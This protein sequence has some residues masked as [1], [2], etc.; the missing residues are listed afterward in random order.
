MYR[1]SLLCKHFW[2]WEVQIK[3]IDDFVHLECNEES[4][5]SSLLDLGLSKWQRDPY[6]CSVSFL[7]ESSCVCFLFLYGYR[8]FW[9]RGYPNEHSIISFL[10]DR[11][12]LYKQSHVRYYG[13][14]HQLKNFR[15]NEG[16]SFK[17]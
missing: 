10:Q 9:I 13:L 4:V 17:T 5:C 15:E 14:G 3:L 1:M 6:I 7:C 11:L 8:S 16:N 2:R 12:Y